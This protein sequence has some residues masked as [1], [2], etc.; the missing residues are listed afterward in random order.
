MRVLDSAVQVAAEAL[1]VAWR[2]WGLLLA[3]GFVAAAL[4]C[5]LPDCGGPK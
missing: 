1:A 4:I 2:H 3:V 5:H